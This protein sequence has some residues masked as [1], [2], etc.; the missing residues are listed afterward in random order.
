MT[1]E[2]LMTLPWTWHGPALVQEEGEE[3]YYELRVAELPDFFVAGRSADEV[4][5]EAS[6]ALRAFLK[7]YVDVGET[8]PL[9]QR[10]TLWAWLQEKA[11]FLAGVQTQHP[12]EQI[13]TT[14]HLD[15]FEFA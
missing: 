6:P 1:L 8:P 14:Q 12:R 3:P 4:R 7:S 15:A 2:Q 13:A 11:T 5:T 9:A 10:S